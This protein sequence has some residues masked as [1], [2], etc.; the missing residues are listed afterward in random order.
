MLLSRREIFGASIAS[1]LPTRAFA[2]LA[3]DPSAQWPIDGGQWCS[4]PDFTSLVSGVTSPLKIVSGWRPE[5]RVGSEA[6]VRLEAIQQSG[7]PTIIHNYGHCGAGVTLGLGCA[8]LIE[9]WLVK[10]ITASKSSRITVVGAGIIG[11]TMAFVLKRRGYTNVTIVARVLASGDFDN[12]T[13]VSDIA[14]GQFEAAGIDGIS[15]NIVSGADPDAQLRSILSGTLEALTEQRGVMSDPFLVQ[16]SSTQYVYTVVRNYTNKYMTVPGGL[17]QA[18]DVVM[19]NQKLRQ[20]LVQQYGPLALVEPDK[21]GVVAPFRGLQ[22]GRST[23]VR[24][25]VR[26][27]VLI[28]TA[29]L[30]GNIRRYLHSERFG[31]RTLRKIGSQYSVRSLADLQSLPA[32]VIINCAGLGGAVI[33]GS[34]SGASMGGRYGLLA[35]LPRDPSFRGSAPRYLYSGFGYMFPRSDGTIVGGAWDGSAP[36][37]LP[38]ASVDAIA[39]K[40]PMEQEVYFNALRSIT[41][42]DQKRATD[43][44]NAVGYFFLGRNIDLNPMQSKLEWMSGF[45]QFPCAKDPIGCHF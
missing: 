43:M 24:F 29:N 8:S 37:A 20:L 5:R 27:T 44:V 23:P 16:D 6:R 21:E 11:L 33:G 28:N 15:G 22:R 38:I 17:D 34:D 13:T 2:Q 40:S 32:D 42:E 30:I 12:P 10:S 9:Q 18:S 45:S 26:N 36:Y 39:S 19:K 35:K 4:T 3:P 1:L 41:P 14:G 25:G 7:T 31:P